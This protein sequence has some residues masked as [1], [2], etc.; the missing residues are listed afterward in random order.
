MEDLIISQ[1]AMI[2]DMYTKCVLQFKFSLT[3]KVSLSVTGFKL[4][5]PCMG[6]RS[7]HTACYHLHVGNIPLVILVQPEI[8]VKHVS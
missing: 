4:S 1:M 3:D 8:S 7:T 6:I 2:E 5:L